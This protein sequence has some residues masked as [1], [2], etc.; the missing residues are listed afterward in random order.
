M[1]GKQRKFNDADIM[2]AS[3][4]LNDMPMDSSGFIYLSKGMH[5]WE[6]KDG[7]LTVKKA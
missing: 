2:R 3:Q 6:V 1:S 7:V 5:E 4:I